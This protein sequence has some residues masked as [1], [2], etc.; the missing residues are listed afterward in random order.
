[1]DSYL[2]DRPCGQL[3]GVKLLCT[4][5]LCTIFLCTGLL[6]TTFLCTSIYSD[7]RLFGSAQPYCAH[8]YC[9]QIKLQCS[10]S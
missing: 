5:L 6:C 9:A 10:L 2:M 7:R 1:M 8:R 3:F 4:A